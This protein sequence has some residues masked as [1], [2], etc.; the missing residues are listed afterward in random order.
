MRQ[1]VPALHLEVPGEF[2]A[3][4]AEPGERHRAH[5]MRLGAIYGVGSGVHRAAHRRVADD[6]NVELARR[7]HD[8]IGNP[9]PVRGCARFEVHVHLRR[10][11]SVEAE[12]RIRRVKTRLPSIAEHRI[13]EQARRRGGLPRAV[14]LS[15]ALQQ[16][17]IKRADRQTLELQRGKPAIDALSTCPELP[18]AVAGTESA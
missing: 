17:G 16:R 5:A 18:R 3:L 7:S 9:V 10:I 1:P 15:P 6:G 13:S 4:E 2:V 8:R 12:I 14:I 11:I